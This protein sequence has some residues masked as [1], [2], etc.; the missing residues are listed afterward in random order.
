M[1]RLLLCAVLVLVPASVTAH[2]LGYPIHANCP[3]NDPEVYVSPGGY[4]WYPSNHDG[5][6]GTYMCRSDAVKSGS[7][8]APSVL[9]AD[10]AAAAAASASASPAAS[11][12][13][14]P[15]ATTHP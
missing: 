8:P 13:P 15:A 10:A 6:S 2:A 1:R 9:R 11:A 7:K 5:F 3:K 4:F 14:S 12:A